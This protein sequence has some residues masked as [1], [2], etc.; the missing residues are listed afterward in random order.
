MYIQTEKL[1]G[2]RGTNIHIFSCNSSVLYT[3]DPGLNF[4]WFKFIELV[5]QRATRVGRSSKGENWF[6]SWLRPSAVVGIK[7]RHICGTQ[8]VEG[9]GGEGGDQLRIK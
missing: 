8:R 2:E 4:S 9:G 5:L 3:S 6:H 1:E 7:G